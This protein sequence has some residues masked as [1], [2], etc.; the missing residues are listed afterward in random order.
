MTMKEVD[1][2]QVIEGGGK[3]ISMAADNFCNRACLD[4]EDEFLT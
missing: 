4:S 1:R 2:L 3:G